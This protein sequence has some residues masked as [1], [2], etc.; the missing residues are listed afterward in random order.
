VGGATFNEA[1]AKAFIGF[2]VRV[3]VAFALG[4]VFLQRR[5]IIAPIGLHAAFNGLLLLIATGA[6]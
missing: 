2:A 3:P 6:T 4:W 5:S 1:I